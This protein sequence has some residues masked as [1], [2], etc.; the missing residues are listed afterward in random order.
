MKHEFLLEILSKPLF[1]ESIL[2]EHKWNDISIVEVLEFRKILQFNEQEILSRPFTHTRKYLTYT[3]IE[4]VSE[5]YFTKYGLHKENYTKKVKAYGLFLFMF[6]S[7]NKKPIWL[8]DIARYEYM[9][10]SRLWFHKPNE[11]EKTVWKSNTDTYKL[12]N[13]CKLGRFSFDIEVY[14]ENP[15]KNKSLLKQALD[16]YLVFIGDFQSLSVLIKKVDRNS[17]HLLRFC[18]EPK[19]KLQIAAFLESNFSDHSRDVIGISHNWIEMFKN[20]K[21]LDQF[22]AVDTKD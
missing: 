19:T 10:F 1:E 8:L 17:Y 9:L 4:K 22:T 13:S 6:L 5:I 12:S 20:W 3:E 15:I 11:V 16:T 18:K 2:A 7:R 14:M 21:I